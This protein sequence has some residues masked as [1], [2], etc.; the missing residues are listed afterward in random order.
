MSSGR[1]LG[2]L[3]DDLHWQLRQLCSLR[4]GSAY[5]LIRQ[6]F[7]QVLGLVV[8]YFDQ[9]RALYCR[10]GHCRGS[11]FN[12]SGAETWVTLVELI[13]YT[14][15]PSASYC[16]STR[17]ISIATTFIRTIVPSSSRY[18]FQCSTS[19]RKGMT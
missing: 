6:G 15:L 13:M 4:D 5:T 10:F 9:V 17:T 7:G 14:G 1:Y 19:P 18:S 3:F 11:P 8:L 2:I 12:S 16:P